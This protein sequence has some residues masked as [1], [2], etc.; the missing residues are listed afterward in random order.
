MVQVLRL[1]E[2]E[3]LDSEKESDVRHEYVDGAIYAMSGS[4]RAHN[5]I[6]LALASRL[7]SH[8]RGKN[9]SVFASDMK[10]HCE[11]RG[12][13][14]YPDVMVTCDP[15][16]NGDYFVS[17]PI[18]IVEVTSPSGAVTDRREKARAYQ[19]IRSLRNYLIVSQTEMRIQLYQ[20]DK[21]NHW[22]IVS[23]GPDD[24]VELDSVGLN[25]PVKEIYEDVQVPPPPAGY[26][27]EDLF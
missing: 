13:Y 24:I 19:R 20:R 17:R 15:E 10:V 4:S 6:S 11:A 12:E 8:L 25:M 22:W 21:T 7:R 3:Y 5:L 9:C 1:T 14:Y 16:D 23:Y 26:E 27:E 18:L 2:Q